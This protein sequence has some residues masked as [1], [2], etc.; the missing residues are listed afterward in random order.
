MVIGISLKVPNN[1]GR[2]LK[3]IFEDINIFKYVWFIPYDEVYYVEKHTEKSS[4][5]LSNVINGNDVEERIT[6][7]EY[8]LV[9]LEM[10]GFIN[11]DIVDIE[12]YDSYIKSKCEIMLFC[13]DSSYIYVYCKDIRCLEVFKKNCKKYHF[14]Y[15]MIDENNNP[16]TKMSIF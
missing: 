4:L 8:Y 9:F 15:E 13:S 1:S 12:T 16:R 7:D 2:Y 10:K 14:D 5:F 3:C 6:L 11:N